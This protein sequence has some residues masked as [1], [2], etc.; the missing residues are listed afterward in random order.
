[1]VGSAGCN[2]YLVDFIR[3]HA[4]CNRLPL[5]ER[6]WKLGSIGGLVRVSIVRIQAIRATGP[7]DEESSGVCLHVVVAYRGR[8]GR[9]SL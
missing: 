1:M 4:E 2:S 9:R 7:A 3:T 8:I 6:I 5:K